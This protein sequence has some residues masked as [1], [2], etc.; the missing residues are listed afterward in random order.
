MGLVGFFTES[1]ADSS[2]KCDEKN[3]GKIMK[4]TDHYSFSHYL[5]PKLFFRL[6]L[7]F[8]FYIG[9]VQVSLAQTLPGGAVKEGVYGKVP[10]DAGTGSAAGGLADGPIKTEAKF[11]EAIAYFDDKIRADLFTDIDKIE[12][13]HNEAKAAWDNWS[14]C[15]AEKAVI[16]SESSE[17]AAQAEAD[18]KKA[19][20]KKPAVDPGPVENYYTNLKN[21]ATQCLSPGK[22]AEEFNP[23]RFQP[24]ILKC[25]ADYKQVMVK[26]NQTLTEI[27][28]DNLENKGNGYFSAVNTSRKAK[29]TFNDMNREVSSHMSLCAKNMKSG[30]LCGRQCS[31]DGISAGENEFKI[32]AYK[33]AYENMV[34][35]GPNGSSALAVCQAEYKNILNAYDSAMSSAAQLAGESTKTWKTFRNVAIGTAVVGAGIAT[36]VI[37]VNKSKDKKKEKKAAEERANA[38]VSI[39]GQKVDCKTSSTYTKSECKEALQNYCSV[40]ANEAKG[41]CQAFLSNACAGNEANSSFCTYNS[42]KNYCKV[43]GAAVKDSPSCLFVSTRPASC[44]SSPD[45]LNCL[46]GFS[47]ATLNQKCGTYKTDPICQRHEAGSLLAQPDSTLVSRGTGTNAASKTTRSMSSI[48]GAEETNKVATTNMWRANSAAL[49]KLCL[50]GQMVGCKK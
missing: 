27:K 9:S 32:R 48:V 38:I 7:S 12:K 30:A 22:P 19:N 43:G 45:S 8:V 28:S 17:T 23:E 26:A 13:E 10:Y 47:A 33:I 46:S 20:P 3:K 49:Q 41:G 34:G 16:S 24:S 29:G 2:V 35:G 31:M 1:C 36:A 18:C 6:F 40:E 25:H 15:M 44:N 21:R 5:T 4:N 39:D 42:S 50:D 37:L 14:K 11:R